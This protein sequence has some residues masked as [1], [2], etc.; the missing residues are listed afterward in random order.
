MSAVSTDA[1]AVSAAGAAGPGATP[2]I[3]PLEST[4]SA[5]AARLWSLLQ[6]DF[7]DELGWDD[8]QRLARPSPDH[9]LLGYKVCLAVN[10]ESP[11]W[12]GTPAL[13]WSCRARWRRQQ[14]PLEV[15]LA[16][17]GRL[18]GIGNMPPCQV[19]GCQRIGNSLKNPICTSHYRQKESLCIHSIAEFLAHPAVRPKPPL[20]LCPVAACHRQRQY[21]TPCCRSHQHQ[22]RNEQDRNPARDFADWCAVTATV[23]EGTLVSF[24]GLPDQVV[25]EILYGAQQRIR[26]H[27][28]LAPRHL[29]AMCDQAR[30]QRITSLSELVLPNRGPGTIARAMAAAC[31]HALA[32][33]ELEQLKDIWDAGVF[34]LGRGRKINFTRL[35]QDWLRHAAKTWILDAIP[36][37]YGKNIPNALMPMITSLTRLS[38]SLHLNRDDHGH[39]PSTLR[40]ADIET[41]QQRLAYLEH[42]GEIS[43]HLRVINCRWCARFLRDVREMGLTRPTQPLELLPDDF[44]FRKSDI[45]REIKDD[46]A[47]RALPREILAQLCQR[48][49]L[50]QTCRRDGRQGDP[51]QG[52]HVRIAM[53][54]LIDTG[55][56]PDEVQKLPWDCLHTDDT[57]KYVLIYT[58]FKNNRRGCR[59]PIPDSTAALITEQKKQVRDRYPNTPASELAL[60]PNPFANP[61]GTKPY[62][63]FLSVLHR[64]WLAAMPTLLRADG[65]EFPKDK[66]TL[67]CY[68]HSYA[69]RHADAGT[70]VDVLRELMG[71]RSLNTTQ[72]YYRVSEKRTRQAVESLVTHQFDR[73]GSRLWDQAKTLFDDEHTRMRI[74]QVA[75]PF[76]VC[77]EPSNVQ[78]GGHAC[79]FR[80]RCLGCD[81]FRTDPSYLPELRAYLDTLLRD[82]E[83]LAAATELDEWA[84][85]EATPS[86]EEITRLRR[87]IRHVETD[88]DNL[89]DEDRDHIRQAIGTLRKTRTVNLGMPATAPPATNLRI[90]RDT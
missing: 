19:A 73:H 10:C 22:W 69:Q 36:R 28:Q 66:I 5:P 52:R 27:R 34:G 14:K 60:F 63:S 50:M 51:E 45:P 42:T 77:A 59:L 48:L 49:P 23:A 88:L 53:E 33:P 32:T 21:S 13:C 38:D 72:G 83:R 11:A 3:C 58:D 6:V 35:R 31:Q 74:G 81:H 87:L 61:N 67:Y 40:R 65:T 71:H 44:T 8:Q 89:A 25:A 79:P 68:R 47:G 26:Q 29:R 78:A 41:F 70:P 54:V 57:G 1:A 17:P 15:F 2:L 43:P 82:R 7:L 86:E 55:R 76:G 16:G 90:E 64:Q 18:Y 39:D 46:S 75:V 12:E 62:V 20:E 30:A 24:R 37:R 56:R 84:R 80:F 9:P 4:D 85:S